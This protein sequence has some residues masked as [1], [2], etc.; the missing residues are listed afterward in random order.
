[1][2]QSPQFVVGGNNSNRDVSN[3]LIS[4]SVVG[5]GTLARM[6]DLA[7]PASKCLLLIFILN[8]S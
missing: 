4:C 7:H 1:M 5:F 6:S 8:S 2:H 3:Y